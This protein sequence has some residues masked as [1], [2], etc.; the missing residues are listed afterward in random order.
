MFTC[1]RMTKF[2]IDGECSREVKYDNNTNNDNNNNNNSNNNSI[3]CMAA[4]VQVI[5]HLIFSVSN[6]QYAAYCA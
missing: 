2:L 6:V 1:N 5:L 3:S 4:S